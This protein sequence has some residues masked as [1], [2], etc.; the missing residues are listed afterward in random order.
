MVFT[1]RFYIGGRYING[2]I[3]IAVGN[4]TTKE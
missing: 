3:K 1:D 2:D 4:L